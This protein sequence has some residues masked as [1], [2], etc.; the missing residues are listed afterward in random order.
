MLWGLESGG[1]RLCYYRT[2]TV[3]ANRQ[4]VDLPASVNT[5]FVVDNQIIT[6]TCG[7]DE[8]SNIT[9]HGFLSLFILFLQELEFCNLFALLDPPEKE[10]IYSTTQKIQTVI[11]SI[12]VGC[13][14]NSDINH[15]LVPYTVEAELLGLKRFPDQ[16]QISRFLRHMTDVSLS[17]MATIFSLAAHYYSLTSMLPVK[18]DIDIDSTGLIANGRTYQ[19]NR[20]GYFSKRRGEKGYQIGRAHV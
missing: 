15:Q 19:L 7:G 14:Y 17:Q 18:V 3:K 4:V 2:V 20:K 8:F 10:V 6:V 5:E 1:F 13:T 11:A 16:S 12:A 9:P